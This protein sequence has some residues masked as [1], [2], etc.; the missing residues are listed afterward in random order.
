MP[1]T[2]RLAI[3]TNNGEDRMERIPR[4]YLAPLR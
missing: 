4:L 3:A 2:G 1:V